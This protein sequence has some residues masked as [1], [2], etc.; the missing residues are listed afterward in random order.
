MPTHAYDDLYSYLAAFKNSS[1]AEIISYLED[2]GQR[3]FDAFIEGLVPLIPIEKFEKQSLFNF[4]ADSTLEGGRFPCADYACREQNI[5]NLV[6]F[7]ALYADKTL[8]HCPIDSAFEIRHND[9]VSV[10]ELAFGIYLTMRVEDIVK[11]GILGFSSNYIPL[12]EDCL[13]RQIEKESKAKGLI[14]SYWDNLV[15]QFCSSTTCTVKRAPDGDLY[16]AIEGMDAYGS[17]D[18]VDVDFLVIPPEYESLYA[19]QGETRL[20][21]DVLERGGIMAILLPL[22]DDCFQALINPYYSNSSYLTTRPAQIEFLESATSALHPRENHALP[23]RRLSCSL[24]I[25]EN[26]TLRS[27][28]DCRIRNEE[29]FLVFRD[30]LSKGLNERAIDSSTLTELKNGLIEPELHKISLVMKNERS[31]LVTSTGIEAAIGIASLTL[32][33]YGIVSPS[34]AMTILGFT[35]LGAVASRAADF[36]QGAKAKENPMYFLWKLDRN[37]CL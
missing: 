12:C 17:H 36:W 37:N 33:Q 13:A 7:S 30:A 10:D 9:Y 1:L 15:Q 31:R 25:A 3:K 21:K 11:A 14:S 8:I 34:D 27:I 2:L 16:V 4:S 32:G 35:G 26:A 20:N 28:L 19:S 5:Y 22:L 23:I 18:E 6:K 29:S 24:P